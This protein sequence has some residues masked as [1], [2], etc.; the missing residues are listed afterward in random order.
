M[1]PKALEELLV[2]NIAPAGGRLAKGLG[3]PPGEVEEVSNENEAGD[4]NPSPPAGAADRVL[5]GL[6]LPERPL[7]IEP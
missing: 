4:P 3:K 1:L 5:K 7:G 6:P 2:P